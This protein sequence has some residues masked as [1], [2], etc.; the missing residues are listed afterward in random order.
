MSSKFIYISGP[1]TGLPVGNQSIPPR[2]SVE[3]EISL[4]RFICVP[5]FSSWQDAMRLP[6]LTV[7]RGHV[8]PVLNTLS[9]RNWGL[10]SFINA[11]NSGG[12]RHQSLIN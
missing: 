10:N 7:G 9:L 5:T 11:M 6:Y 12:D 2:T 3:E 8:V 4:V 1:M